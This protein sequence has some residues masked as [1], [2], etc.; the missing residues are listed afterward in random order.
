MEIDQNGK[1]MRYSLEDLLRLALLQDIDRFI[2]GEIKDKEALF[3]FTT[4][5]NTGAPFMGTTHSNSAAGSILRLAQ[6]AKYA[7][8]Y[9]IETL[10][11]ML[12]QVPFSLIHMRNFSIHEILEIQGWSNKTQQLVFSNVFSKKEIRV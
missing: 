5:I 6:L 11:E 12:S 4:G 3:V 7:S 2:V 1:F 8:D 9:S 10:E